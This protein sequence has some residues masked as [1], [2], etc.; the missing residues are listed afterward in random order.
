MPRPRDHGGA[1]DGRAARS[2]LRFLAHHLGAPPDARRRLRRD[3]QSRRFSLGRPA[4]ESRAVK[5]LDGARIFTAMSSGPRARVRPGAH[6]FKT[7]VRRRPV[8]TRCPGASPSTRA[9]AGGSGEGVPG[10]YF[11]LSRLHRGVHLLGRRAGLL[12]EQGV[13][14]RPPTVP[15]LPSGRQARSLRRGPTRVPRRGV[16]GLRGSGRR[17][18]RAAERST[19][20]LQH[21]LRQGPSRDPDRDGLRLADRSG[22][23]ARRRIP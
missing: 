2:R 10:P 11:D 3:R 17:A 4:S 21:V 7:R 6:P 22:R 12:L 8:P 23:R 20:L 16:R 13:D 5:G 15:F 1:I 9:S 14:Q 19:R 18:I